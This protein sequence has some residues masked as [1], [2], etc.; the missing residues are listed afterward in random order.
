MRALRSLL[1]TLGIAALMGCAQ[2]P[3]MQ[4]RISALR[5][6][7][8]QADRNGART[9]APRELA[10][11]RAHAEFADREL[12][13]GHLPRAEEH[14]RASDA[15]AR[16]AMTLSPPDRCAPR[17]V[18][19]ASGPGDRDGDGLVDP[20]DQC[21]DQPENYNGFQDTDGCPDELDSDGDGVVDAR[22]LCPLDP[23]DRDSY[24]DEDG[25]PE[26][27][28]DT[29]GIADNV[30]NCRNEP[31]D[32]DGFQDTDGCPDND[33]DQDTVPD[34]TDRCPNEAGP[35]DLQGCPPVFQ[36]LEVTRHGVRFQVEFDFDR[37]TLR[38]SA[39]ATL[40][41]VVQFLNQPQNRALRYEVGGHT[42]SEGAV[43]H[44]DDLSRRRALTVRSY[45]I[46]HGIESLRLTSHGYGSR[47]P[48]DS[49]RSPEGRQRN[50]RVELNEVDAQ[51]RLVQ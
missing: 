38:P 3:A 44:N 24:L 12:A 10:L 47:Q 35:V 29:D 45:L 22:D 18:V 7:L 37:A 42:S 2:A 26:L 50:R 32:P 27:D 41:E 1:G 5:E 15:N 19:V 36:H 6:S 4:G 49:N 48:I 14:L 8:N 16:A 17:S 13:E 40:D 51:G 25:C 34:A 39:A 33:N 28:N 9:C 11:G 31:E 43:R 46:E 23:E 21:P 20:E 30:D